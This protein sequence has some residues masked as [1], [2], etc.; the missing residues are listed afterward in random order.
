MK[1]RNDQRWSRPLLLVLLSLLLT[2][3][4]TGSVCAQVTEDFES[5]TITDE[6]LSLTTSKGKWNVVG[7]GNYVGIATDASKDIQYKTGYAGHSDSQSAIGNGSYNSNSWIITPVQVTGTVTYWVKKGTNNMFAYVRKATWNAGT[8][9]FD[10]AN[11]NLQSATFSSSSWTQNS[12]NVGETPTYIAF[13]ISKSWLDDVTYT[14]YVAPA[15][16]ALTVKDGATTIASPYA[17]DFGTAAVGTTHTFTLSNP[18][19]AAVE[20]LSVSETGNFGA[21]LSA[22]TI[23]AGGE[24][25]LTITMP[26][27]TGSS[28]ITISST[29][30]GV[31]DFVI[32]ASGTYVSNMVVNQPASLS[33][34]AIGQAGFS[35]KT[36]TISNTGNAPLEGITVTTSESEVLEYAF[37]ISGVPTSLAAGASQEVTIT[38]SAQAPLTILN[39]GYYSTDIKVNATGKE[40]VKFAVDG[41]VIGDATPKEEFTNGLPV[42][43]TNTSWT[44]ANGEASCTTSAQLTTPKLNSSEGNFIIVKAKS[45]DA[46]TGNYITLQGSTDNGESFTD[47]KTIEFPANSNTEFVSYIVNGIPAAVNKIRFKGFYAVVDEITNLN[48]APALTV[49]TGEPAAT[50]TSPANYDFGECA[51]N[52][53]VTYS[54]ANTGGGTINI[55]NVAI[56]GDGAAAYSTNWTTSVA[57][58]FDLVISRTYDAGRAGAQDAVVTVT[59]SEGNFVI[60]VTGTDMAADAPTLSVSTNAIDFGKVTADA[61]Q[62]VTVTNDGTGSM[63]VTIASDNAAFELSATSLTGIGAGESKT[64]DVTFKFGTPYGVKNGN[65]TVTPSYDA[66]A[67]QVITVTGKAKDPAIWSEDFAGGTLPIG[68]ESGTNWTIAEG[69]AKGTWASS[70]SYLTTAPLT[71]GATTDELTF[72]YEATGNYTDIVIEKS[73]DGGEFTAL[74]TIADLSNGDAGTYTITGLEAGTYK[75]RFKND[76]YNLDNFEGFVLNLPDHIMVITASN[77]PVSG[78]KEG[79]AFNANVTVK[80]NR[81]VAETGVVAKVYMGSTVIGTSDATAFNA[82]ESKIITVSCTP[83]VGG[84]GVQM[85]I[86]VE[87]AG[88]TLSTNTVSRN[89]APITNLTLNETSSDAVVAGTY[90]NLTLQRQIAAGWNTVCLP[91]DITN[92][93]TFFGTGA[94]AYDFTSYTDGELGFTKVDELSGS[95]PYI[96]Y[97]PNAITEDIELHNITIDNSDATPFYRYQSG[98]YFRGTY[99]PIAAGGWTK[100]V[101]TDVIYGVSGAGKIAPAQ[102]STT[103]KGFRAYFDLPEG[104]EARL[105]LYDDATGITTVL[106]AKDLNSDGKLYN[107]NGQ[108]VENA[109]KGLYIVNGRKVVVK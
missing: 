25:T 79:Q 29:T 3:G 40:E 63:D 60:N 78:L 35:S 48:Y 47:L 6:G 87:Y 56:T 50:V 76:N 7:T 80:E 38:M 102:A 83:N 86:E 105:S 41:A 59:T 72:D 90:D 71:V 44:F 27:A 12:V 54:F 23:A 95:Y 66:G 85:H 99:A 33:F 36:F 32:N 93:E 51:A 4:G 57:A 65:V 19:T 22:N 34:G 68:W 73:K 94:K 2:V 46:Y 64:F 98:A 109:H 88:G 8:S 97:V 55:T 20:G 15:G 45:K 53:T 37:H 1:H 106:N 74:H 26:A 70:A 82:G 67:A 84:D 17:F 75:F 108:R 42:N 107:L 11:S 10:I 101:D 92:I 91:F 18:G 5:A 58:P 100:T 31:A 103:M 9:T 16:A 89:V 52:A 28:A 96:V 62:T 77:I 61:V 13:Q 21:T 43:W 104:S 24:A 69:K 81:G 49:T 14:P 39:V 30:E